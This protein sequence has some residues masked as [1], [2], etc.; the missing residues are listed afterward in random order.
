M[1][2]HA[3]WKKRL[4]NGLLAKQS[5]GAICR[6]RPHFGAQ[7][8]IVNNK[9]GSIGGGNPKKMKGKKIKQRTKDESSSLEDESLTTIHKHSFAV[10]GG[11]CALGVLLIVAFF[12]SI[13]ILEM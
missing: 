10:M 1:G 6:H 12:K 3:A 13:E 7:G 11:A 2:G 5:G 9:K 8:I 4:K